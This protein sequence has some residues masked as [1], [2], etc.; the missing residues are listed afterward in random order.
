MSRTL[1]SL[2]AVVVLSSSLT[3]SAVRAQGT[4]VMPR[5]EGEPMD[6]TQFAPD[7]K[8]EEF[9]IKGPDGKPRTMKRMQMIAPMGYRSHTLR[10]TF[11][12][13]WMYIIQGDGW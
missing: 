11:R 9:T 7:S 12:M 6:A 3:S 2:V 1:Y 8:S 13:Q 4:P 10:G 5:P